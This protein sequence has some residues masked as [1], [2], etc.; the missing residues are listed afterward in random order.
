MKFLYVCDIHGDKNK[1]DKV[2]KILKKEKIKYMV[3][4]GD[5]LPKKIGPRKIVQAEFIMGT[6]F[7]NY[8]KELEEN[9]IICVLIPGNDDLEWFDPIMERYCQ[10][11]K[12]LINID[13][14]KV[15]I[16]DVE[17][18]GLSNVLDNP[19]KSKNRVLMEYGL[20]MEE[21]ISNEI[22]IENDTKA[23]SPIEWK[24][25]RE[26]KI[27]KMSNVLNKLPKLDKTKKSIFVFHDPPYGI[28]LDNC[29]VGV[30]AGSKD[31][32]KYIKESNA[33]MSFHGH[34]HESPD[35]SGIWKAKL[36]ETVCIQPGQT[37]IGEDSMT[38][39]IVDTDS[40]LVERFCEKIV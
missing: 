34:I 24:T 5:F 30:K 1:Y 23:I 19:F 28:G 11:Y 18:I 39:V 35:V 14:R 29:L 13:R 4:G 16:D 20:E 31:I 9:N 26:T 3:W 32:L 17:F 2:L 37:E 36:G 12:N 7:K 8:L 38:Y 15:V 22:W 10:E 25:Y 6:Y 40:N 33:Y 27:Q 21:Q